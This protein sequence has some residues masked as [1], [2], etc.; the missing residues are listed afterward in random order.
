LDESIPTDRS[1]RPQ[2]TPLQLH[3]KGGLPYRRREVVEAQIVAILPLP[4]GEVVARASIASP[5]RPGHLHEETIVYLIRA[6]H[7]N[8]E[9]EVVNDLVAILDARC[10]QKVKSQYPGINE[11]LREHLHQDAFVDLLTV[12]LDFDGDS[13]DYLQVRFWHAHKRRVID[14]YKREKA[15]NKKLAADEVAE[16]GGADGPPTDDEPDEDERY[17]IAPG[18]QVEDWTLIRT[19]LQSLPVRQ[20]EAFWLHYHDGWPIQSLDPSI[21]TVSQH[22]HVTPKTIGNWF[23]AAKRALERWRGEKP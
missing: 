16:A 20:A 1:L 17:G 11:E 12:L 2:L 3:D 4:T 18:V 13:G 22:F 21:P 10:R 19:A 7:L 5:D 8:G 23:R 15:W 6:F 14:A 9:D